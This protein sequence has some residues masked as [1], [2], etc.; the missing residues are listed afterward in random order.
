MTKRVIAVMLLMCI[1]G[2]MPSITTLAQDQPFRG[3][4]SETPSLGEVGGYLA[5]NFKAV[6]NVFTDR[7]FSIYN[8][9]YHS[10]HGFAAERVNNLIDR[11]KGVNS[12]VVGD[13]N[14]KD[15]PD[16]MIINRRGNITWIQD[17]YCKSATESVNAA[18]DTETGL[19]RYISPDGSVIHLEVPKDQFA[20][21]VTEM[22]KRISEG[23]VP[24]VTNPN[25]AANIVRKGNLT[26]KQAVNLTKAG[27]VESLVYD[28]ARG[29]V[30][31][32]CA[33][34]ISFVI[35]YASCRL[36]GYPAKE[37]LKEASLNGLK[38]GG[39]VFATYV[40]SSQLMKTGVSKA[41]IPAGEAVA[42]ALG[43]KVSR[44]IVNSVGKGVAGK[45]AETVV[46]QAGKILANE[47][48][49]QIV[50]VAV[51]T[52]GDVIELM[53][54]RISKEQLLKNLGVALI[55]AGG[56]AAGA[57]GGAAAGSLL[58]GPGTVIG[59]IVGGIAGGVGGG[60]LGEWALSK[61]YAGDAE[62][63]YEIIS[64]QFQVLCDD[65]L[66]TEKEADAII[67]KLQY[68][69]SGDTLKDMFASE[70]RDQFAYDLME[71]LFIEQ[72]SERKPIDMPSEYA[73]RKEYKE[74][75]QGIAFIH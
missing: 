22:Q 28:A 54:G 4:V 72:L 75:M 63:M 42:R 14:V 43:D 26:Y 30:A 20:D 6:S 40:I 21:A 46:K 12:L 52:T 49:V 65:C 5:G 27:T 7:K 51:L 9:E 17:K 53:R 73:I 67:E 34:G 45:T 35:D 44:A 23:K 57:I 24:G 31:A 60:A 37:A 70:D 18:F 59:G 36:N 64:N 41:F 29:T 47:M 50:V 38:T 19:Y 71:P 61:V 56:A 13:N 2:T 39:V 62:I 68:Q 11:M 3:T 16:R 48:V 8:P 58:P 1:V 66:T 10:K 32:S 33:A 15:G 55:G 69:L 74:T 25:E